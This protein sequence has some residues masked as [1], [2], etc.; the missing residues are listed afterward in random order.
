MV[1]FPRVVKENDESVEALV[2][3]D[4]PVLVVCTSGLPRDAQVEV[5]VVGFCDTVIPAALFQHHDSVGGAGVDNAVEVSA[6]SSCSTPCGL[7]AAVDAWPV[8]HGVRARQQQQV[9][10]YAVLSASSSVTQLSRSLCVGF[11]TVSQTSNATCESGSIAGESLE[12]VDVD[13]AARVL[14]AE[15]ALLLNRAKLPSLYLRSLR[16]YFSP[17]CVS[18][19][20]LG[21]A[22]SAQLASALGAGSVPLL[23]VPMCSLSVRSGGAKTPVLAAQVVALDSAQV[24]TEA[25]IR[26]RE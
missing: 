12:G 21:I 17:D 15:V 10:A 20:D 18:A 7:T 14:V 3:R 23:L 11:V 13:E 19:E 24:E 25:W 5:E 2:V 4:V 6:A 9:P 8:W 26:V 22:L 16:V 1:T